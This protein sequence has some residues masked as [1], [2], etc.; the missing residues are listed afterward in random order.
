MRRWET[1]AGPSSPGESSMLGGGVGAHRDDARPGAHGA[2]V[3][4]QDLVLAELGDLAL[5]L[6]SLQ[7]RRNAVKGL[8]WLPMKPKT[9]ATRPGVCVTLNE[10]QNSVLQK[11]LHGSR[12]PVPSVARRCR[13]PRCGLFQ[14]P[15]TQPM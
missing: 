1:R 2:N 10:D 7:A 4:H 5:L 11:I 13:S 15:L 14:H 12:R 8:A 3:E 6:A 9:P